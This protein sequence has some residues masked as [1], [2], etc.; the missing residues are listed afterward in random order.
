MTVATP[1]DIATGVKPPPSPIPGLKLLSIGGVGTGKTSLA[2]TLIGTG[3]TPFCIC[4]EPPDMLG[5]TKAEDLHWHYIPP[6]SNDLAS[7]MEAA[8]RIGTMTP[9]QILKTHDTNRDKRNNFYP[10]L[11][12]LSTYTCDR[13]GEDFGNVG[14][15]GTDRC[16]VLDGLS[17]LTLAALKLSVGEKYA[18]TQP[19]FQIAM[20]LIENILLQLCTGFWCHAYVIAHEERETDEV[21]GGS[22]MYASTLGRKLAPVLGRPFTDV[23]RMKKL[24][25]PSGKPKIVIDNLETQADLKARNMPYGNAMDPTLVPA[26]AG[27][28]AH[29]GVISP[30]VPESTP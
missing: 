27:W 16:L 7:L 17:G 8:K 29:G 13:T 28:K 15:W 26:V 30:S 9:E 12:A 22:K 10:F 2:K 24:P 5:D 19:E 20:K 11:N 6:V 1:V 4:F 23:F 25:V 18:L 14:Q 3:I 21:N